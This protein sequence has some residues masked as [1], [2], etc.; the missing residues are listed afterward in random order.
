MILQLLPI[1]LNHFPPAYLGV[2]EGEAN[3]P[4]KSWKAVT[5]HGGAGREPW[6]CLG[7]NLWLSA[8][9]TPLTQGHWV[10]PQKCHTAAGG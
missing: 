5:T 9:C 3:D 8:T 7:A 10:H 2:L 6:S 4:G 1:V